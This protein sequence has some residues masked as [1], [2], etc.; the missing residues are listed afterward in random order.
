MVTIEVSKTFDCSSILHAPAR[1]GINMKLIITRHAETNYNVKGLINYDPS[2]DV[3]LTEDGTEQ[4]KK[5]AEELQD[6]KI[7]LIITS[8]LKRTKQTAE[9]VNQY[10][11][12]P[13]IEDSHLDDTRNGF[14]GRPCEEFKA[15][16]NS[17]STPTAAKLSDEWESAED[18]NRRVQSFLDGIRNR[19]EQTILV[20]T[21]SHPARHFR[22]INEKGS[23]EDVL[24]GSIP[25]AK[26][27]EINI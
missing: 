26:P 13:V 17:H 10:H 16:R 23:L 15:F 20:V 9:I 2:V 14:E 6:T 7:D 5:L 22:I 21:S 18:V 12:A 24:T 27:Y 8:R 3:H 4:A 11:N 19:Q 25:N 1:L